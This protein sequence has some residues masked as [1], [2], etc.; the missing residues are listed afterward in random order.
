MYAIVPTMLVV[1]QIDTFFPGLKDTLHLKGLS[2]E[3]QDRYSVRTA[4]KQK[5]EQTI[6]CD[7]KTSGIRNVALRHHLY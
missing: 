2:I 7:G 1:S 4:V 6:N 3:A 5:G